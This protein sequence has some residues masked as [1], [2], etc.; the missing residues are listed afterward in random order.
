MT[1]TS[2]A[3][4]LSLSLLVAAGLM[5]RSFSRLMESGNL[6]AAHLA[7]LRLRP[8]LVGYT[9]ERAQPYLARA[10]KAIRD[11]PGV[12]DAV[13]VRHESRRVAAAVDVTGARAAAECLLAEREHVTYAE[14]ETVLAR[15][16]RI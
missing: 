16:S 5:T 14:A 11:V 2:L 10:L 7:Q 12:I 13:P 9:P 4:A 15:H 6:D 8:R 1:R 3:F